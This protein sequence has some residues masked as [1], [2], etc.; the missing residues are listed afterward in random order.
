MGM[1]VEQFEAEF[2]PARSRPPGQEVTI[3][4]DR[5]IMTDTRHLEVGM[6]YRRNADPQDYVWA[7]S[8]YAGR[9]VIR[10]QTGTGYEGMPAEQFKAEFTVAPKGAW[11]DGFVYARKLH[12]KHGYGPGDIRDAANAY[13]R[14]T[15]KLDSEREAYDD[16]IAAYLY[17]TFH[18]T[19]EAT[20]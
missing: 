13:Q 4:E 18:N 5:K 1:P 11:D 12:T 6:R 17:A 10:T 8:Q 3:R 9:V 15:Y 7:A 16:G 19:S 2:T 20:S 14:P